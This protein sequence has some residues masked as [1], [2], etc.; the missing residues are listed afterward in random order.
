MIHQIS[1]DILQTH[2]QTIVNPVNTVGV[3]GKGLALQ[4]KRKYP[5]CMKQYKW[6]CDNHLPVSGKLLLYK[7]DHWILHFPTKIYS[8]NITCASRHRRP[9]AYEN[10]HYNT[11]GAIIGEI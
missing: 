11:M 8:V 5:D 10:L 9:T 1:G 6:A 7:A 4:I 2:C 3:M